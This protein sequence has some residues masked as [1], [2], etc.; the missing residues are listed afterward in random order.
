M[1]DLIITQEPFVQAWTFSV[2]DTLRDFAKSSSACCE[3]QSEHAQDVL[4]CLTLL[5]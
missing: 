5:A 4:E 3:R 1:C 2:R